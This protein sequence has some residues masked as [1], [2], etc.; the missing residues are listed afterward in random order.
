MPAYSLWD[1]NT[2]LTHI[3]LYFRE[4]NLPRSKGRGGG[5]K[6]PFLSGEFA[7]RPAY[8]WIIQGNIFNICALL[9]SAGFN[10]DFTLDLF[11]KNWK[12]H[13]TKL[14]TC[15]LASFISLSRLVI[16][17][18]G[19][20]PV[21]VVHSSFLLKISN[22]WS[23]LLRK[24]FR[25]VSTEWSEHSPPCSLAIGVRHTSKMNE[26]I[27]D[28]HII[29]KSAS[30]CSLNSWCSLYK[31]DVPLPP[32]CQFVKKGSLF[33]LD[34]LWEIYGKFKK[35]EVFSFTVANSFF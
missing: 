31:S 5:G 14:Y 18:G 32:S 2:K 15:V 33:M 12:S 35:C 8:T 19:G 28:C 6:G 22:V 26:A 25:E 9:H 23:T 13:K 1:P 16:L 24:Y 27:L 10:Y 17:F 30:K 4:K 34:S 3:L 7:K 29:F 21:D 11:N 20:W